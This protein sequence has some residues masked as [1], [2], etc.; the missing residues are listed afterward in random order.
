[1]QCG[2]GL[3]AAVF[4]VGSL[5]AS[6]DQADAGLLLGTASGND[7]KADVVGVITAYN[8]AN[9]T[10]LST[11]ISLFKKTDDNSTFV[12]NASNGF[13]FYDSQ[14]GGNQIS[15]ENGLT[16]TTTA[17][18]TY[19]GPA[20]VS[21][22]SLKASGNFSVYS[23]DAGVRNLLQVPDTKLKDIS[24]ASFWTT[25]TAVPEPAGIATMAVL[26][27]I[28]LVRRRRANA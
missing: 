24:H 1:M 6:A 12:F 19:T 7:H 26:G 9:T 11:D 3:V 17:W 27:S 15:T 16:N 5:V 10:S 28:A 22:Y 25:P 8:A 21:Y 23:Y 18:F 14:V 13:T 4:A 2:K 20:S